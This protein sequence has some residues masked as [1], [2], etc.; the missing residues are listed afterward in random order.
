MSAIRPG[1]WF[2]FEGRGKQHA[3]SG[4]DF[5]YRSDAGTI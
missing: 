3:A 2:R 5:D 4:T 1:L